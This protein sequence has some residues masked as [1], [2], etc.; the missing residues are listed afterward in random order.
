[1]KLL[2]TRADRT[3]RSSANEAAKTF[4]VIDFPLAMKQAVRSRS[5]RK[6][7]YAPCIFL[8][9]KILSVAPDKEC[10]E[11]RCDVRFRQLCLKIEDAKR[12]GVD[13]RVALFQCC[14][15]YSLAVIREKRESV[16]S[17]VN[18]NRLWMRNM[19]RAF[20]PSSLRTSLMETALVFLRDSFLENKNHSVTLLFPP[21]A[22]KEDFFSSS[23]FLYPTQPSPQNISS[24]LTHKLAHP[25]IIHFTPSFQSSSHL[26]SMARTMQSLSIILAF[27]TLAITTLAQAPY[28]ANATNTTVTPPTRYY[29]KTQVLGDS[30]GYAGNA[31]AKS[32]LYVTGYHTGV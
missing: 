8:N 30:T 21:Y 14:M 12:K 17:R 22:R 1:M 26:H 4:S 10:G 20:H 27:L 25:S 23:Q 28:P 31:T 16:S 2:V 9:T 13:T 32:G 11:K 19:E 24:L 29:L 3:R 6:S 5:C 7:R 18:K 15:Q